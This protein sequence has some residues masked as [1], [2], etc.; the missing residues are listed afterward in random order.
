MI[1]KKSDMWRPA[2]SVFTID[3]MS[4]RPEGTYYNNKKTER[5]KNT[6]K[7]LSCGLYRL[8]Y[9]TIQITFLFLLNKNIYPFLNIKYLFR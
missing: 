1:I 2:M 4:H 6:G 9:S 5:E 8:F 3:S 7:K